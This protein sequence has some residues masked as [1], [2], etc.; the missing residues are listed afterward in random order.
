[1]PAVVR[2]REHLQIEGRWK[3]AVGLHDAEA[4]LYTSNEEKIAT[5][6]SILQC[7]E[8]ADDSPQLKFFKAAITAALANRRDENNQPEIAKS[9]IQQA[10]TFYLHEDGNHLSFRGLILD[11]VEY[12]ISVPKWGQMDIDKLLKIADRSRSVKFHRLEALVMFTASSCLLAFKQSK[13]YPGQA[14]AD[15]IAQQEARVLSLLGHT[16]FIYSSGL[17]YHGPLFHDREMCIRW[18]AIFDANYPAYGAW[19]NRVSLQLQWQS[20]YLQNEDFE[21]SLEALHHAGQIAEEC[22]LFWKQDGPESVTTQS[23]RSESHW[24]DRMKKGNELRRYFFE[25]N[26]IDVRM[27]VPETGIHHFGA[28]GGRSFTGRRQKPF[29]TL[30]NWLLVDFQKGIL[31]NSSI[32]VIFENRDPD[33]GE[34]GLETFIGSLDAQGLMDNFYGPVNQPV[35]Y[36]RWGKTFTTL[37]KWIRSTDSFPNAQRQY[38]LI[39]LLQARIVGKLPNTLLIQECR[40]SLEFIPSLK[41]LEELHL[42]GDPIG[43]FRLQCQIAFSTAVQN[44]W[45]GEKDW[46]QGMESL[47]QEAILMLAATLMGNPIQKVLAYNDASALDLELD[48]YCMIY[49]HIGA[50]SIFKFQCSTFIDADRALTIFWLAELCGMRDRAPLNLKDGF[51]ALRDFLKALERPWVRDIFPMAIRLQISLAWDGSAKLPTTL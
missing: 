23:L 7:L 6:E 32:A 33:D 16:D 35:S 1:M 39:E 22:C 41:D 4:D 40:R 46:T 36:E 9:L 30:L 26:E 2:L 51:G 24:L 15:D 31:L 37:E 18:W 13:R 21:A 34:E 20:R 49:Y 45:K 5:Q 38:M 25:D 14:I 17:A 3:E 12:K 50:L 43:L 48:T 10:Q 19:K 11:F 47:F 42:T 8:L 28:L 27:A 29:K 44:S